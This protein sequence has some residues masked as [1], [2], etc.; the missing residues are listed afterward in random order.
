MPLT[1]EIIVTE[2][3]V[4][5]LFITAIEGG[6]TYWCEE[7]DLR[8][9]GQAVTYQREESF[10]GDWTATVTPHEDD[11]AIITPETLQKA[12]S[13]RPEETALL[14]TESPAFDA[15]T[16]DTLIQC[17]AFGEIVYG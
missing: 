16:A 8:K 12:F 1:A 11:K 5:D 6:S 2:K 4:C 10:T 9:D 14:V 3:M 17:A 15:I 13:M 7:I